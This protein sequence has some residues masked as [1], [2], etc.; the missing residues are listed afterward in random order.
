MAH[1]PSAD[2]AHAHAHDDHHNPGFIRKY[3]F[4]T[5]HKVI[6][7]QYGITAL[8][9]MAFGF[10]LMMIMRWSIA[11]PDHPMPGWL[12]A[13]IPQGWLDHWAP[14]ND[15]TGGRMVDGTLYNMMGAMHG[16]IMVFLAV[17]P[18]GFG[19]FGNYVTPLQIG[20]PDMAFPKLNMMSYWLYF[21]G[22]VMMLASFF[23]DTGAAKTG[24]TF[25]PPLGTTEDMFV[26]NPWMTGQTWWLLAM[27]FM[28]SSS[29]L[30]SVNVITTIINLR[31]KGMTW[32][33]LPFFVWGMLVTAFLLLLAFPPLE[34]AAIMQLSDRVFGSSFFM[35]TG[36]HVNGQVLDYSGGGSP[37]LYQ[38]LFWFLGHPEVYVLLLPGISIVT[39]IV[40]N[41]T[42][43]PL[44]GYKSMVY[45][46]LVLGF[47]SF[48]VWAHHMYL[49]GMGSA[50]S[51][52][53]QTTTMLISIPSVILLTSL[54]ISLW[55]GSI[56]FTVPM[57]WA[58]AFLPMFGIGGL[59]GLPLAFNLTDLYLHDTY[60][61]IA[62]FHYV[63]AP[64]IIFALFAGVYYWYPKATGRQ[65]NTFL[66]HLHFWPSLIAINLVFLPM[67][68]QGMAG[69]HRRWYNGGIVYENIA[70][71][72]LWLN[73]VISWS[74]WAL[75]IFQLP[76][77]LNFFGSLWFG[78]KVNSDNPWEATT[79][80]WATPTPP[81]HGNF[82]FEPVVY[83]GPYEYSV[84]GAD[85][86]FTPQWE[87]PP[88]EA[89]PE[90]SPVPAPA[91]TH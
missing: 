11:Y 86:D 30:G 1:A 22:G 6:G 84:P 13:A 59:T 63:V 40:A 78:K 47:L 49:T 48:I 7:I 82:T 37:L 45:A 90:K 65:M 69:F 50:V 46:V 74:V 64:G 57:L 28:I 27:V 51:A 29:L 14:V 19:A 73:E 53:F 35:P 60:Y 88:G 58:C 20:A 26:S 80:E 72:Y 18:L 79:L 76:F 77:I 41:N 4:S 39:E 17:V 5:D 43:K 8:L 70:K 9:F 66:G 21:V 56:R 12:T 91:T 54:F 31:A 32:F 25:Y 24:W 3:I 62:H 38:H 71:D 68:Q 83:R 42:R 55:G 16:T 10:F 85:K 23:L 34:V 33:R 2:H 44:W 15:A 61:V 87:I 89:Q 75:A 67:F 36:L 52:F 81:G